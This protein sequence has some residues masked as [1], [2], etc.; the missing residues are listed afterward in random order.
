VNEPTGEWT[1]WCR[2]DTD[3]E[4][5][6]GAFVPATRQTFPKWAAA[7]AFLETIAKESRA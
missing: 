7:Q 5:T 2:L 1:V 3:A 6:L 4:G